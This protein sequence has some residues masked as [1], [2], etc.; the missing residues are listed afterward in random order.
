MLGGVEWGVESG[1]LS[2]HP[3]LYCRESSPLCQAD[4]RLHKCEFFLCHFNILLQ[5][6]GICSNDYCFL[7]TLT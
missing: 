3:H 5:T 1:H 6:Q 7:D 2:Q 4:V